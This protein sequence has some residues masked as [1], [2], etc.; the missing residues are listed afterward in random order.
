M[1]Y[2]RMELNLMEW[3]TVGS[4]FP[5]LSPETCPVAWNSTSKVIT[6]HLEVFVALKISL[7]LLRHC[8]RPLMKKQKVDLCRP[9]GDAP[10]FNNQ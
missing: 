6:L 5:T 2:Q 4:L 7:K 9:L 10:N 1:P 3:F 8:G